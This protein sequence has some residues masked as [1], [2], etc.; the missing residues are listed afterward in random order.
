MPQNPKV[1]FHG[2]VYFFTMSVEEGF[3]FPPNPLVREIV[4]KS[5][6]QA[7]ALHP[8][9]IGDVLVESTHIHMIVQVLDPSDAA[10]FVERFKTESAHAI[11]RL[12]GRKKRTLWCEGYDSP[13]IPDLATLISKIA[14]IYENPSKDGLTDKIE[15]YPG[16]NTFH[17]RKAASEGRRDLLSPVE[18]RTYFIPRPAF[19]P[20][21][22]SATLTEKDYRNYRR[23]LVRRKKRTAL[24]VSP[25]SILKRFGIESEAELRQVN[26]Q[27]IE[28]VR[29]REEKH[30]TRRTKEVRAVVGSERLRNTPIGG[31][32]VPERDGRRMLVHS[33]DSEI[34]RVVIE[35]MRALIQKGKEVLA[36]WKQGETWI[37]YPL[38]LFPPTGIRLAEPIFW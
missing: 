31:E 5:A 28:E 13:L 15:E 34:R 19:T 8:L 35:W 22:D 2:G 33:E 9:E 30:R 3:M 24:V 17:L 26:K 29:W 23:T 1:F 12:L 21:P 6:A 7:Q 32:Y 27:I 18:Y 16:F 25:N 14:Y 10:D 4:L 37:S 36:R 20:L 38:G 11:N